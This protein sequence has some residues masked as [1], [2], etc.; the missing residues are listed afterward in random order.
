MLG[1]FVPIFAMKDLR[2]G[3]TFLVGGWRGGTA[4]WWDLSVD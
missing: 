2:Q 3:R 1:F 4:A